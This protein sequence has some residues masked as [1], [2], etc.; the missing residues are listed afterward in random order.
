MNQ[1]EQE[2]AEAKAEIQTHEREVWA[3]ARRSGRSG[4]RDPQREAV[5][6]PLDAPLLVAARDGA[7]LGR[8]MVVPGELEDARM[9]PRNLRKRSRVGQGVPD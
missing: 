9:E 2:L 4:S 1:L 7:G 8:E 3:R 5:T 6:V